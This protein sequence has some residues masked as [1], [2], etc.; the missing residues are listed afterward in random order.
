[1]TNNDHFALRNGSF[2]L[3]ASGIA[4]VYGSVVYALWNECNVATFDPGAS[5]KSKGLWVAMDELLVD[6]L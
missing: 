6:E 3:E 5:A 2:H 1:M 4:Y